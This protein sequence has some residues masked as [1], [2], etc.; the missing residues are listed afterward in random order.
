M[1]LEDFNILRLVWSNNNV[2]GGTLTIIYILYSLYFI[3]Y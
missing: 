3:L 1:Q 2:T